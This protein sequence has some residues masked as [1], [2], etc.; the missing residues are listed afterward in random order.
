M[1]ND[2][3]LSRIIDFTCKDLRS[4]ITIDDYLDFLNTS[5]V[6]NIKKVSSTDFSDMPTKNTSLDRREKLYF[7]PV[8]LI[9]FELPTDSIDNELPTP[10]KI[11]ALYMN[12]INGPWIA[13]DIQ[14]KEVTNNIV[15][16]TIGMGRFEEIE[17]GHF[18]YLIAPNFLKIAYLPELNKFIAT[19]STNF[20]DLNH[21]IYSWNKIV[22]CFV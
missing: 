7:T 6:I 4:F 5:S 9:E 20:E 16:T 1:I 2:I 21:P 10:T 3:H 14:N 15:G 12:T 13:I 19:L 22:D 18:K 11:K 8:N 17:T